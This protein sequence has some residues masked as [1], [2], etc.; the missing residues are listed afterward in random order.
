MGQKLYICPYPL[1][2]WHSPLFIM[3]DFIPTLPL[4]L[5]HQMQ[6]LLHTKCLLIFFCDANH[7]YKYSVDILLVPM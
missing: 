5:M 6:Y 4:C 1:K 7:I 2:H 3:N